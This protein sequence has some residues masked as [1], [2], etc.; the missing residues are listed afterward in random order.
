MGSPHIHLLQHGILHWLQRNI[1]TLQHRQVSW[2]WSIS[3]P[4]S[5]SELGACRAFLANFLSLLTAY[6]VFCPFLKPEAPP[7]WWWPQL[8]PAMGALELVGTSLSGMG[9]PLASLHRGHHS[10]PRYPY[11]GRDM[12]HTKFKTSWV[13]QTLHIKSRN[14]REGQDC[15]YKLVVWFSSVKLTLHP[16]N[17]SKNQ[18]AKKASFD[19]LFYSL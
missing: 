19:I 11:P 18:M 13:M 12:Q 14:I 7:V 1:C 4:P 8:C 5:F 17:F 6:A 9:Q 10:H 16:H 15:F 3:L 2:S